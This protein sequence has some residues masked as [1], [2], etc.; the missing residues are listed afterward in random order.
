MTL[1][2]KLN[3]AGFSE[4]SSLMAAITGYVL[5]EAYTNPEIAEIVVSERE[6]LAYIRTQNEVGYNTILSLYDLRRNWSGLLDAATL[7]R[8]E[9]RQAERLFKQR[10]LLNTGT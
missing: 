6:Q 4:M 5:Q 9:R 8:D 7:T 3:P 2:S 1:A 10:V